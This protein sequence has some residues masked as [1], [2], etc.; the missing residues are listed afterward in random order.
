MTEESTIECLP[1][2]KCWQVG[3]SLLGRFESLLNNELMSD[4]C[5]LISDAESVD[6]FPED[7]L[8]VETHRFHGHKMILATSS[9]V[10]EKMFAETIGQYEQ[11]EVN[12]I[13]TAAFVVMLR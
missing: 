3:L 4:V 5:F 6:E 12:D 8:M 11:I 9:P 10:F 2:P 13:E 1:E 7:T